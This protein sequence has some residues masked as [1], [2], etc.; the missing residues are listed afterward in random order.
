MFL[1]AWRCAVVKATHDRS[2]DQI[3]PAGSRGANHLGK[4]GWR[5]LLVVI[6][7]QDDLGRRNILPCRPER[8]IDG[9][10]IA[11]VAYNNREAGKRLRGKECVRYLFA[12]ELFGI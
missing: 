12:P 6:D 9:A 10:A 7:Y 5:S 11:L 4:P 8:R 1:Q 2:A 3:G